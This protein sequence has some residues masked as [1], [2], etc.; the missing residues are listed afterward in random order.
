MWHTIDYLKDGNGIQNL[1]YQVMVDLRIMEDLVVY[2]PRL[3]GTIPIQLD[4]ATSDLDIICQVSDL[5]GFQE[6][7]R[8]LYGKMQGYRDKYTQEGKKEVLVVNFFYKGFA[9]ELYC[10]DAP[11]ETF[12][13]Y[14]HMVVEDRILGVLGEGFRRRIVDLKEAGIKTEPAFGQLL[15]LA[16]DPYKNLLELE[17]WTDD[18]IKE[19]YKAFS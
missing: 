5:R 13:S 11:V 19:A 6:V 3:V 14:R 12:N 4:V 10:K 17:S 18:Q 7:I 2:D 16:G 8:S 9:F 15:S 1:A